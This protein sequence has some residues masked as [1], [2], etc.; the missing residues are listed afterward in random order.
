M[1]PLRVC[2][3]IWCPK[4]KFDF[5]YVPLKMA[6]SGNTKLSNTSIH[7]PSQLQPPGLCPCLCLCPCRQQTGRHS[8][9]V[10]HEWTRQ[11]CYIV[12]IGQI[13][14][15][16]VFPCTILWSVFR[17]T[18]ETDK[19]NYRKLPI[20]RSF[21]YEKWRFSTAK[22]NYQRDPK[23]I[24]KCPGAINPLHPPFTGQD[25]RNPCSWL[26]I[27]SLTFFSSINH[28]HDQL[29][30]EYQYIRY[31]WKWSCFRMFMGVLEIMSDR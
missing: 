29:V 23:G 13:F 6:G 12:L 28:W 14:F 9:V 2:L 27:S 16:A 18:S 17:T 24:L 7:L 1:K 25:L 31:G 30:N 26:V 8:S 20:C 19:H 22:F 21:A 5:P 10:P 11:V 15:S 3:N 4:Q